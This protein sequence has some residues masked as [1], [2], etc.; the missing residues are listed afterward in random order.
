MLTIAISLFGFPT[1]LVTPIASFSC[2][3][4]SAFSKGSGYIFQADTSLTFVMF[5][6]KPI[7]VGDLSYAFLL[8]SL[9]IS[10]IFEKEEFV[11]PP[12]DYEF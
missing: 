11:G 9:D 10:S 2:I 5:T 3:Q 4:F 8:S 7:L 6:E 12:S 1:N